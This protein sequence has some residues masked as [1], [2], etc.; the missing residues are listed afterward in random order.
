MLTKLYIDNYRCFVNFEFNPESLCLVVGD[1][2]VGKSSIFDVVELLRDFIGGHISIKAFGS[3]TLT[4][5][6][7]LLLQTFIMEVRISER[8]YLYELVIEHEPQRGQRRVSKER[9]LLDGQPLYV[10][11]LDKAQFKAQLFRDDHSKGPE[12][13]FDWTRSGIGILQAGPENKHLCE[14]REF[15]ARMMVVGFLNPDPRLMLSVS[16]DESDVLG[17]H[18]ESFVSWYR[19]IALEFPGAVADLMQTLRELFPGFSALALPESGDKRVLKAQFQPPE[20]EKKSRY[21]EY[22]FN[23]LSDGQRCLIILYAL[24]HVYREKPCVLLLDEPDN[25]I[26]L[27]EIQPWLA[28]LE[29]ICDE[30]GTSAQALIASHNPELINYL[31]AARALKLERLNSG[32]ARIASLQS[33]DGLPLAEIVARGWD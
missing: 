5:W 10:A 31:G 6:Q 18:G 24:L 25:F 33:V 12:I 11:Q 19:A 21:N 30:T 2:G 29:E 32:A 13:S 16:D 9:L 26:A 23:E 1:N 20:N 28:L 22:F 15:V 27:R 17:R 8:N 7:S 3:D 4:R 14:F